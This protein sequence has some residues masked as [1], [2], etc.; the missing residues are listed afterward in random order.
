ME[1]MQQEL[2]IRWYQDHG[3]WVRRIVMGVA[4][5]FLSYGLLSLWPIYSPGIIIL[6][7]VVLG[8]VGAEKPTY[9]LGGFFVV[10]LPSFLYGSGSL[11]VVFILFFLLVLSIPKISDTPLKVTLILAAPFVLH[12]GW[13]FFAA[14]IGG[15]VYANAAVIQSAVGATLAFSVAWL[16]GWHVIG[17]LPSRAAWISIPAQPIAFPGWFLQQF[18]HFDLPYLSYLGHG[19]APYSVSITAGIIIISL[20]TRLIGVLRNSRGVREDALRIFLPSIAAA[21]AW[22]LMANEIHPALMG[23]IEIVGLSLLAGAVAFLVGRALPS[24]VEPAQPMLADG[25]PGVGMQAPTNTSAA[26]APSRLRQASWDDI[27]GYADV[28]DELREAIQPYMDRKVRFELEKQGLPMVGGILLYGAPGTGKTLFGRVLASETNMRF[29]NVSGSEFFS[30][31]MGESE[32]KLREIFAQA[33]AAAPSMIFFDEVESF[34][35]SRENGGLQ[36]G[37]SQTFRQVVAAFLAEMDGAL[38]RGDVL[39]VAATNHPDLIDSAAIRAGRFDK[40]IFIPP[41]DEDARRAILTGALEKLNGGDCIAIDPLVAMTERF[42]AADMTGIL[43]DAYRAATQQGRTVTQEQIEALFRQTKPTVTFQML[44]RYERMQ[45]K[46]GRRSHTTERIEIVTHDH[47]D[48]ESIGGMEDAKTA[49]REAVELP[50]LRPELLSEW[51]VKPNKGVLLYGPPGC[52][53]T[54]FAKVVSDTSNS[55][56]YTINGPELLGGGVGVAEKR[57]REL[58]ER[59]RENKPAVLFFDEIDAIASSRDSYTGAVQGPI[60]QQLLTL[61]DG[62][63][64]L[65]GVVVIAATNRPDQLDAA[66]LRPGRFDRLIYIPL[67]DHDSRYSQWRMHLANKPGADTLDY[68]EITTDSAGYS[69]AEIAHIVNKV[70]MA[71]LKSVMDGENGKSLQTEDILSALLSTPAQV[72]P[73]QVAA[74][75]AIAARL[76]R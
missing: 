56:F 74:Y 69:G 40:I 10:F 29:F 8:L 38:S 67:P 60:V 23:G 63:E 22:S 72:S 43:T 12:L 76:S 34:L 17:V 54:T 13:F 66:L 41:P 24:W 73:E 36:D 58:F 50:L 47:L 5:A 44:E 51:G 1:S 71:S 16:R 6:C 65:N 59:A 68:E 37:A 27:A 4:I 33:R 21:I 57:L 55:R 42:T 52:G 20:T 14:I 31:W 25:A 61:M 70:A 45:D 3:E 7:A 19:I 39:V 15:L 48:W 30:M 28:K 49:L 32:R 75:E 64:A 11:A 35:A 53:K 18:A 2:V 62:K 9:A 26:A 46:F